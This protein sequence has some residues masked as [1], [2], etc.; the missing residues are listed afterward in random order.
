[1]E[2]SGAF[3]DSVCPWF[4]LTSAGLGPDSVLSLALV[5]FAAAGT[6]LHQAD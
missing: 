4:G 1:M 5:V 2:P 6:D 3:P